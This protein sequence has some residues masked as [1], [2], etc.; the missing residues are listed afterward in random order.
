[1]TRSERFEKAKAILPELPKRGRPRKE[2]VAAQQTAMHQ[3]SGG[4]VLARP[5]LNMPRKKIRAQAEKDIDKVIAGTMSQHKWCDKHRY[6]RTLLVHRLEARGAKPHQKGEGTPQGYVLPRDRVSDADVRR[7]MSRK[8]SCFA[9][10]KELGMPPGTV[11][12]IV[13]RRAKELGVYFGG[14]ME[15]DFDD[16]DFRAFYEGKTTSGLLATKYGCTKGTVMHHMRVWI[17]DNGIKGWRPAYRRL[18]ASKHSTKPF[19]PE[20]FAD[21]DLKA[22][23]ENRT[24]PEL[25]MQKYNCSR[26]TI[27]RYTRKYAERFGIEWAPLA[28]YA[29][30]HAYEKARAQAAGEPE[31]PE[32]PVFENLEQALAKDST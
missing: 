22:Y 14:R 3:T 9:L 15:R 24:R 7:V 32:L 18:G 5:W 4:T 28:G 10:S 1:M 30:L 12:R 19:A 23:I 20:S 27:M 25:L 21:E 17:A 8:I 11:D 6:S 13:K 29:A 31:Q 16:A 26:S 2:E